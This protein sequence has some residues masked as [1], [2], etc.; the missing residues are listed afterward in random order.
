MAE[1]IMNVLLIY[2]GRSCEHDISIITAMQASNNIST[3]HKCFKVYID[4]KGIW[5]LNDFTLPSQ[6]ISG[7]G[8]LPQVTFVAGDNILYIKKHNTLKQVAAID[9]ALICCHGINGEDGTLQG[10]LELSN[11]PYSSSCVTP[12]GI[13]CDKAVLKYVLKGANI[14][15]LPSL[16][17]NQYEYKS[18]KDQVLDQLSQMG[19][20]LIVKP[21]RMGSSIGIEVVHSIEQLKEALTVAYFFDTKVVVE[22]ALTDFYELNIAAIRINNKIEVSKVEMPI[23]SKDILS[24]ADKYLRSSK[25]KNGSLKGLNRQIVDKNEHL[26]QVINDT[27]LLYHILECDGTV[28]VDFI[29]DRVTNKCYLSEIN[30]IPGSLSFYLWDYSFTML[31]D[32]MLTNAVSRHHER[33]ILTHSY[34]SPVIKAE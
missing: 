28:R 17:I 1:K 34:K 22:P 4:A 10:L 19:F 16:C 24:F 29:I 31:I 23:A 30:M 20:P 9:V 27:K 12:C 18:N 2:G 11:I 7:T 32:C 15:T 21:S 26:E 3:H 13:G 6:H 5:R 8:K 25:G 33:Q 14:S